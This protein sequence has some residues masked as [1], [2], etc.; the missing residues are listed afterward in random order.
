MNE[1]IAVDALRDD[2][3]FVHL[4]TLP[5]LAIDLRYA[6]PRNL[7]GHDLYAPHDCAWL[8]V[9]AAQALQRAD[10]WLARE[11][12]ALRLLVLDAVRP[13]RVQ[14]QF[15]ARV[16][17][18][19]MQAYF[20][21]P[22]RGSIHSFGMAVDLTLI[23]AQGHELDLGTPFDDTSELAHPALEHAHAASGRLNRE[24]LARR[25]LLRSAMLHGGWQPIATEWWHF[26]CG[27]RNDVRRHW[28]R[29]I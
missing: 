15:W 4:S 19:P 12:P 23:D 21:P 25:R 1:S 5:R 10:E 2:R 18:T 16:Q 27:D 7:L 8:H 24:Q 3:D 29:I 11:H 9:Q 26:D 17:G 20:A 6:S 13:Q 14:E 28:R 22:E